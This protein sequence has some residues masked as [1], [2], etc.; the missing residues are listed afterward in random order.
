MADL[1]QSRLTSSKFL[2]FTEAFQVL[3]YQLLQHCDR[4]L[5]LCNSAE[6]HVIF[7]FPGQRLLVEREARENASASSHEIEVAEERERT[8]IHVT[9]SSRER[10]ANRL[11]EHRTVNHVLKADDNKFQLPEGQQGHG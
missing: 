1:G 11:M 5:L 2:D 9:V 8:L 6:V 7:R 3:V 10:S 4:R